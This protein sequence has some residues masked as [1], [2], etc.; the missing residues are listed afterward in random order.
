MAAELAR[1]LEA[2]EIVDLAPRRSRARQLRYWSALWPQLL[3]LLVAVALWQVVAWS[4][5]RPA[6]ELPGPWPVFRRLLNDL[7]SVNFYVGVAIT[8]LRAAV[9]YGI[10][11]RPGPAVGLFSARSTFLPPALAPPPLA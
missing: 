1:D 9:G 4:G 2:R 5:W 7:T 6:S 8:L 10:A 11:V 3:A